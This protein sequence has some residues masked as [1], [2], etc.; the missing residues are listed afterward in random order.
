MTRNSKYF[1]NVVHEQFSQIPITTYLPTKVGK[2]FGM[3][4]QDITCLPT[5]VGKVYG[6]YKQDITISTIHATA[7]SK[8]GYQLYSRAYFSQSQLLSTVASIKLTY[9]VSYPEFQCFIFCFT[10]ISN[11][12]KPQ[13]LHSF[14]KMNYFFEILIMK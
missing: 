9:F 8:P 5:K 1:W 11:I 14:I 7:S 2:V 13:L 6:M 12:R 3:C 10:L 4:K